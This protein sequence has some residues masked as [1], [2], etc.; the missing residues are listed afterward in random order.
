VL[1][2]WDS[3]SKTALF[4]T[5]FKATDPFVST[6]WD[7]NE[8]N[9]SAFLTD[10]CKGIERFY[11]D[12]VVTAAMAARPELFFKN[13][14]GVT[15]VKKKDTATVKKLLNDHVRQGLTELDVQFAKPL[16]SRI[17]ALLQSLP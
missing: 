11:P 16:I 6:A 5:S 1:L 8:A 7:V 12:S 17:T 9:P 4:A 13:N 10:N 15:I 14:Q 3:A 2:D